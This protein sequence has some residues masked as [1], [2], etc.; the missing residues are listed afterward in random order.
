MLLSFSELP[1]QKCN[2][3]S[4]SRPVLLLL[5]ALPFLPFI[6][7]MVWIFFLARAAAGSV[8]GKFCWVS[9]LGWPLGRDLISYKADA[10]FW[11]L[12]AYCKMPQPH[13]LVGNWHN[14][15]R[16][17]RLRELS[18]TQSRVHWAPIFFRPRRKKMRSGPCP[19]YNKRLAV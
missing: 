12:G 17:M 19:W 9:H 18:E 4:G 6:I 5:P 7:G 3:W 13:A 11:G 15:V 16:S 2:L 14:H 8:A 1:K 10:L